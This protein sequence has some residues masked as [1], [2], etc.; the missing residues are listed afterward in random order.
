MLLTAAG[1]LMLVEDALDRRP[2]ALRTRPTHPP[3]LRG[4]RARGAR[5]VEQ[6]GALGVVESQCVGERL[7]D[8]IG[9]AGRV[10]P[11]Q[12]LVVLDTDPGQ[13]GDLFAPQPG[14][15]SL[16]VRRQAE[17]L[18]GDLRPPGGQELG[19]LAGSV[20]GSNVRRAGPLMGALSVPL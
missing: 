5:E 2:E 15:A 12:S 13:G 17:L 7:E 8:S 20:H 14:H 1:A 6:V 18:R 3:A 9:G 4:D 19:E 11:L 10:A 16:T